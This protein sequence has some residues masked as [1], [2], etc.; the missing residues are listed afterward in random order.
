LKSIVWDT[1]PLISL[2]LNNLLWTIPLLK[3]RFKGEFY[4]T[5]VVREESI[6]KPLDSKKFKFEALQLLKLLNEKQFILV[7]NEKIPALTDELLDTANNIY[8]AKN[9]PMQIVHRG[10][11][12]AL[13]A[14]L[15]LGS[16]AFVVDERTTRKLLEEP[17]ELKAILEEKLHTK[18]DANP[19]KLNSFKKLTKG[20]KV[21]RSFELMIIA[22]ELGI[23]DVYKPDLDQPDRV[24]LDA[25]LWGLK[26]DGC[27]VSE[28][29]I[30]G[31]IVQETRRKVH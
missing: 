8:S 12:E 17:M 25:V 29:E 20:I 21:L 30:E 15:I 13:A 2:A 7:D 14:S 5:G 23:L 28:V 9:H 11:M 31:I 6:D 24:L 18:V 27:A 19:V 16:D 4:I 26:L 10:E 1:S 22:Y 3:K